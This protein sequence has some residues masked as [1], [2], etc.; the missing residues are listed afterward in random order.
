M[1][2]NYTLKENRRINMASKDNK[3]NTGKKSK[4]GIRAKA[5]KSISS[6]KLKDKIKKLWN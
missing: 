3:D 4:E 2:L 6:E 1:M 5:I